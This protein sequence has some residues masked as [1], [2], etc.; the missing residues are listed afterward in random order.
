MTI[1]T[2]YSKNIIGFSTQS[3]LLSEVGDTSELTCQEPEL[4]IMPVHDALARGTVILLLILLLQALLPVNSR[5][6]RSHYYRCILLG[7]QTSVGWMVDGASASSCQII[8][9]FPA[10]QVQQPWVF[11]LLRD[12]VVPFFVETRG[13]LQPT[14]HACG[15]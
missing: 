8:L 11:L 12:D 6:I 10:S 15:S 9:F 3:G 1:T 2:L 14:S 5:W 7:S 13:R 4:S